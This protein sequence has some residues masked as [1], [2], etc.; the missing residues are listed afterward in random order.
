[1]NDCRLQEQEAYLCQSQVLRDIRL[2]IGLVFQNFNLFPHMSVMKILLK[3]LLML[4]SR[5]ANS[6]RKCF[7]IT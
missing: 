4:L 5:K 6:K 3:L 7:K 2:K 1:M